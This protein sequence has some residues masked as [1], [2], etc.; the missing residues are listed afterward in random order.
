V[1]GVVGPTKTPESTADIPLVAQVKVPL[2]LW[3]RESGS[4]ES[5]WVFPNGKGL[6]L[7]G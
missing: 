5:G 4:P 3:R 7:R 2:E 6:P 1:R